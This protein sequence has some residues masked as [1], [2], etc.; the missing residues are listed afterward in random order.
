MFL[1]IPGKIFVA[2]W[3]TT[4]PFLNGRFFNGIDQI[5][6]GS[7]LTL[8][9]IFSKGKAGIGGFVRDYTGGM[10]M[11]FYIP[12]VCSSNNHTEAQI[13]KF[14][15]Q[16]SY[17]RDPWECSL[18]IDSRRIVNMLKNGTINL[19]LRD[20]IEDISSKLAV[21]DYEVINCCR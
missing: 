10:L 17:E 21:M 19:K 4:D 8:M 13:F 18:E 20:I 15:K 12:L 14:G 5:G 7:K 6:A 3:A 9:V 2:F 11:V 1:V 16:W